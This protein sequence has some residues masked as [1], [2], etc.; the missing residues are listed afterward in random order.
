ME[1]IGILNQENDNY[2]A[3]R[4]KKKSISY[5]LQIANTSELAIVY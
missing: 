2:I 4:N 5:I 1:N 3:E